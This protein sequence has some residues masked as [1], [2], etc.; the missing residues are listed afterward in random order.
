MQEILERMVELALEAGRRI[1]EEFYLPGGPRGGGDKADIDTEV[2]A[3]LRPEL[4]ELIPGSAVLGEELG[5]SGTFTEE[6]CWLIDPHD[7]TAAFL[8]GFRGSS[9]SIGLLRNNTPVL[10]VVYAPL[11]PNDSGDLIT[12]GP[13]LGLFR[14]GKPW[15]PPPN[16]DPV[17]HSDIVV[18]SQDADRR[19]QA[20]INA[21]APMRYLAMA[22]IAY[23]LALTA[24]GD[25]RVGQSLVY[26]AEHDV[27][28][29]H[30]L[31]LAAGKVLRAW[32]DG[33]PDPVIY[34]PRVRSAPM[35]GGDP[36]AVDEFC[37]R[38]P[39]AVLGSPRIAALSALPGSRQWQA[40]GWSLDRAQ[41]CLL[42]Q[43]AGDSLGSL[44]EFRT[45]ETIAAMYP[46]GPH[47]LADG[48]TWHTLAGQP[49]DDSEMAL[50]LA[51]Q[52]IQD[53]GFQTARVLSAYKAW[54]KS[55]PFDIGNTTS[56]GLKGRPN[57]DS[58]ANGSLMRCSPLGIA[59]PPEELAL[60]APAD[61]ALTHPHKLCTDCCRVFTQTISHAMAGLSV[62][63]ALEQALAS[64]SGE[65]HELLLSALNA[66]PK[67]FM[68]QM[69]WIKIAFANAFHWLAQERPLAEALVWTVRQG[70]DTDTNAAIAGALLG[71]FQGLSAI[72]RQWRLSILTCRPDRANPRCQ[73]PR[74]MAYW[75]IDALNL[76][77]LLLEVRCRP[78]TKL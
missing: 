51:R 22:S 18:I 12:G 47:E 19:P 69:G 5:G 15:N 44:V 57:R 40:E 55:G 3:F 11:Y 16:S 70:G 9:V 10:G 17:S 66:P 26:L 29:G 63:E 4:Q 8:R 64:T 28:A 39:G 49:T 14:N 31:L 1:R 41:G 27:A 54:H 56:Q 72:P 35:I 74:P 32:Q 37:P 75:P 21:V 43:L 62:A 33:P 76:A 60:V 25:A 42:G 20:N 71:A 68:K 38:D 53:G 65:T 2:E 23:R 48:G 46:N 59:Y 13:G 30:A 7:G 36:V 67:E 52:L 61:S 45:A 34:N 24:A 78:Q 58:Q 6:F 73:Q 50:A 77:E